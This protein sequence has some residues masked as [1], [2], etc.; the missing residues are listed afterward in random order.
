MAPTRAVTHLKE[1]EHSPRVRQDG[2]GA[3]VDMWGIGRYLEN[4]ASRVTCQIAKPD[5]V[6]EMARRWMSDLTISAATALDEVNDL[7]ASTPQ[8]VLLQNHTPYVA[9]VSIE[10]TADK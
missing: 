2:H 5:A 10:S 3:E 4:M 8:M 7:A 9:R 1:S 6:Q